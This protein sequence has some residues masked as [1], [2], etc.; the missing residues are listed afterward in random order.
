VGGLAA[1]NVAEATADAVVI[2]M[3]SAKDWLR[4]LIVGA[5][6]AIGGGA[7]DRAKHGE[8]APEVQTP[9]KPPRPDEKKP[10]EDEA[11]Q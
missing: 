5:G 8:N 1:A 6:L 2:N 10:D 7:P 9:A 3:A 4:R 11:S